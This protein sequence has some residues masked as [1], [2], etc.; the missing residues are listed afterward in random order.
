MSIARFS[1]LPL[2]LFLVF[3]VAVLSIPAMPQATISTGAI[4]GS[5]TDQSGAVMMGAKV[6][7]TSKATGGR[8]NISTTGTGTFNSGSMIPGDYTV[9]ITQ[10]GFKTIDIPVTVQVGAVTT[11]DAKLEVG[12]MEQV[13]EV[14]G[15]A[16]S[17]NTEQAIVQGVLTTAQIDTLPING[18]NFLDLA[19]LEPGVQIQDAM[20]FDPT[21]GGFT[22]ISVGGRTGRT[23][24]IE[25]DGVDISDET[26]GTTVANVSQSAIQ[27]FSISQSSLDLSTELTSSGAVNVVTRAG[28]NNFHGEAF[29]L[30]RGDQFAAR[31]PGNQALPFQRNHFGGRFGGPL[32]KD[33]LFF[34]ANVERIKQDLQSPVAIS[35]PAPMSA[36]SG[37]MSTPFRETMSLLRVDW[38][39][40][41]NARLFYRLNYDNNKGVTNYGLAYSPYKNTNNTPS[42]VW[43]ADFSTGN[44]NHSIRLGYLKFVNGIG[45]TP[46]PVNVFPGALIRVGGF[47]SGPNY[48][49]PQATLQQNEQVKYDGSR[50]WGNHNFRF[51]VG[52]NRIRGGGFASFFG[53]TPYMSG[54]TSSTG[55]SFA[56]DSCD[57]ALGGMS[58]NTSYASASGGADTTDGLTP[59]FTGG[60]NNPLNY[61]ARV[62]ELGNGLGF[63][64][65]LPQ[66]GYP[67]GGQYDNRFQAYIGD[68]WKIKS[69]FTFTA[70][71]RYVRDTG[72]T[73]SDVDPIPCS[74]ISPSLQ[75]FVTTCTDYIF[76]MFG[77]GLANRVRQDNNNFGP[78]LGFTWDPFRTGKTVIRGGAGMYFENAIFNNVLFSRPTYLKTG[79]FW[80][81]QILCLYGP[82][83]IMP[84]G[85]TVTMQNC[86]EAMGRAAPEAIALQKEYQAQSVSAGPTDNPVFI[87]NHLAP[88]AVGANPLAP[89]YRTPYSYQMNIGIQH[90]LFEGAV[91][92]ADYIRNINLHYMMGIDTNHVGDARYLNVAAATDA[93]NFTNDS[94]GCPAGQGGITC[95]IGKGATM[96]DYAYN[97]LASGRDLLGGLPWYEAG[98]TGPVAFGGINPEVGAN[99]MLFPVGRS[100]YNALQ[101]S[102]RLNKQS[103]IRFL[104]NISLQASYTLS[105]FEAMAADQDFINESGDMRNPGRFFGPT[106]FDRTHQLSIGTTIDFPK[107][108]RMSFIHHLGSPLPATL[109]MYAPGRAGEIF[110]TDLTGDG[111]TGDTITNVGNFQ[112]DVSVGGLT[113]FINNFN[114]STAGTLTPAGQALVDAGLITADQ[115]RALGGT[116]DSLPTPVAGYVGNGW[117]NTSDLRLAFPLKI[118]ERLTIEPNV[119]FYNVFNVANFNTNPDAR[120]SGILDGSG[121]GFVTGAYADRDQYRAF[122]SPGMFN[123]AS[124]RQI[125]FQLRITF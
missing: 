97:G 41:P 67:A 10:T 111:T 45:D 70:G 46:T 110:N 109:A 69:N 88:F 103:P 4:A 55:L 57:T 12:A 112:R 31:F 79:L 71:L 54:N 125:E 108:F 63:S 122:Q 85:Q 92:T 87:G 13:V 94:F 75:P 89:D 91:I 78:N 22:G 6:T 60:R 102:L 74:Q 39:P 116:V 43:G 105:R 86:N 66:F 36:F 53:L 61:A 93:I 21:K 68:T 49:A 72:R 121:L 35:S 62:V 113:G 118:K 123:F 48:L 11:V 33:K 106:A 99:D 65:E 3:F 73:N 115:L 95:A 26:V 120:I 23:T 50:M 1:R 51:G 15:G 16:V 34:F 114:N 47:W 119:S 40:L 101:T 82:N 117:L 19:Q 100:V 52:F 96:E 5:V 25:L 64:T 90:Q 59:C 83:M 76:N 30:F 84:N 104:K 58:T 107:F 8:L 17:V 20:N 98:M 42:H 18:R 81:V 28:T 56:D 124:A 38:Q 44:W 9:R 32:I 14:S 77:K 2:L 24:R 37:S 27:E 7:I 29:Y 80:A